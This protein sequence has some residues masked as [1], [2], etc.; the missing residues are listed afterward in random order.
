[1]HICH[2][3]Q[4]EYKSPDYLVLYYKKNDSIGIR[5]KEARGDESV[6]KQIFSF[7]AGLQLTKSVLKIWAVRVL[8]KLD[9]DMSEEETYEWITERMSTFRP[10]YGRSIGG[11]TDL[12]ND[13]FVL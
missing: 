6:G 8:K 5:R 9:G 12:L 2:F 3:T 10:Q 13:I 4:E 1:M 7:G 11:D